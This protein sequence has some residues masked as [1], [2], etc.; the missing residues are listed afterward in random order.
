MSSAPHTH[1]A[2]V[3]KELL[4]RILQDNKR[5]DSSQITVLSN[6]AYSTCI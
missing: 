2:F 3:D 6:E 4:E 5:P 1:T